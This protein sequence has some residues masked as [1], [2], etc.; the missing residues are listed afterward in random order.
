MAGELARRQRSSA[1][2]ASDDERE[3]AVEELHAHYAAGRLT[4][5]E[6]EERVARVY[7]A[8]RRSD[9]AREF[10]ALP[11]R[12]RGR[13][14]VRAH[15]SAL[16]LHAAAYTSVNASLVGVWVLTGEGRF[17]P[18]QSLLP[19]G[20]LLGWHAYG[21]RRLIRRRVARAAR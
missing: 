1:V 5:D 14:L 11:R 3:R 10:E 6:L 7:S 17:W 8:R 12:W 9:I 18:A 4:A 16:R 20:V 19:W 2:L 15:Q 21:Y 13:R